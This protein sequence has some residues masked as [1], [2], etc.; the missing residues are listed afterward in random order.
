MAVM[1]GLLLG[2]IDLIAQRTLPYPWANLANSSAVWAI[3]AF[4]VGVW[5]RV[6]RWLPALPTPQR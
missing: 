5:V 6:G 2:S 1:G 4:G 3:G